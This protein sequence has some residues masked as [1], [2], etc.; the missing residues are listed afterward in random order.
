MRKSFVSF[1]ALLL[2]LITLLSSCGDYVPPSGSHQTGEDKEEETPAIVDKETPYTVSF[3]CDG[4]PVIPTEDI[5]VSWSNGFSIHSAPLDENGVASVSGI[6]GNYN[7]SIS[8]VPAGYAFNPNIYTASSVNRDVKIELYRLTV[9]KGMSATS[10]YNCYRFTKEGIYYIEIDQDKFG[11]PM[12]QY[13]EFAPSVSGNYSVESWVDISVNQ[14]NPLLNYYGASE[15][16]KKLQDPKMFEYGAESSYTRNFKLTVELTDSMIST[17]G[18]VVF[19]F[20]ISATSKTGTYP[21][22][23]Y[24]H[25][26]KNNDVDDPYGSERAMILPDAVL[27]Q[28]RD[29][30]SSY[31]YTYPDVTIGGYEVLRSEDFKLWEKGTGM[32]MTKLTNQGDSILEQLSGSY[33]LT[34]KNIEKRI[35]FTPT[36][37][38][39]GTVSIEEFKISSDGTSRISCAYGN[40]RY[41]YHEDAQTITLRHTGNMEI[42]FAG[43]T[44]ENG[45]LLYGTGD[46]YYHVWD[47]EH[48][49]YGPLLY[50]DITRPTRFVDA[51]FSTIESAGNQA[52]TFMD[53]NLTIF[54]EDW[55]NGNYKFFIEGWASFKLQPGY[56]C[57]NHKEN[58]VYCPCYNVTNP[59]NGCGGAC[60]ID[61]PN[62]HEQCRNVSQELL[63]SQGGYADY[64]NSDG[65]YAVN[66]ELKRFLQAYSIKHSIFFDGNGNA[67]VDPETPVY[68]EQEDQWLF[69]CGYYSR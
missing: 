34:C 25:V 63:D 68:A 35:V 23:V 57:V 58:G 4:E 40:Y 62:C 32:P 16:F 36:N 47:K 65:R 38:T 30:D 46:D 64:V 28:Q 39:S 31:T 48:Q 37:N 54:I 53:D 7:I 56:F 41:T 51:A 19:S 44:I 66:E 18:Q 27:E 10:L 45:V 42:E 14:V 49:T 8:Q 15:F 29:Y 2:A 20:G 22:G 11:A 43:F 21:V 1:L 61:C 9:L 5:T 69:A 3:V 50:A 67:E 24:F 60:V 59:A 12:E 13:F 17:G 26:Y 6:D 52:L 55:V 33:S